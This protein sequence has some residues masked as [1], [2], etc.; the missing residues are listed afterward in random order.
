MIIICPLLTRISGNKILV[1]ETINRFSS[2]FAQ[3]VLR[4]LRLSRF[5]RQGRAS[6]FFLM[7][8]HTRNYLGL[9]RVC[10]DMLMPCRKCD[11]IRETLLVVLTTLC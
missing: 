4:Y 3:S 8:C 2:Y 6:F 7:I 5:R 10:F 1:T 9:D 11:D